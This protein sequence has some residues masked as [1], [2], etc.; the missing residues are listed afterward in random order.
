MPRLISGIVLGLAAI[1]LTWAGVWTFAALVLAVGL[2]VAWEWGRIVRKTEI[3]SILFVHAVSVVIAAALTLAG[4]AMLAVIALLV[5]AILAAILGFEKL[6][7]SSGLGVLYSGLPV[8]VL[9]WIRQSPLY[10]FEA[11]LF[12]LLC[13]WAS[14]TGAYFAG[15]GIGGPKLWPS[16]SPNKTWSGAMGGLTASLLVATAFK[17]AMTGLAWR[18]LLGMAAAMAVISQAGD[19]MES[20]IKRGYGVKDASG[21]IP[22]HGGFMDRVDGLIF[23]AVAAAVVAAV[24]D[25]HAPA[26]AILTW[27]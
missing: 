19:L 3:D 23:A 16:V 25:V 4:L 24:V 12:I 10:G 6:G 18:P 20:A 26:R 8:V 22:G 11:A 9:I 1:G 21:L 5:G 14:D 2:I 15:R 27:L 7:F 13:V 17:L